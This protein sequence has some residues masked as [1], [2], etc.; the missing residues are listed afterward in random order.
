MKKLIELKGE[1]FPDKFQYSKR[2]DLMYY[3]GPILAYLETDKQERYLMKWCDQD[4]SA[5]RWM[6]F[7]TN[8]ELLLQFFEKKLNLKSLLFNNPDGFVSI[9]D[10]DENL[11]WSK[12]VKIAFE[13]IP[14]D[15]FPFESSFYNA[16]H[17]EPEA[18]QLHLQLKC[19][20]PNSRKTYLETEHF[21]AAASLHE[22]PSPDYGKGK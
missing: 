9:V 10:I 1:F 5:N 12:L 2:K 15:Y 8:E 7:K 19:L 16:L 17:Y 22:P 11:K 4:D 18:E 13:Q 20:P 3:E 6:L 21:A 14:S